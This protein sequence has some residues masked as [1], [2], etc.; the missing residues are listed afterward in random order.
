MKKTVAAVMV[1]AFVAAAAVAFAAKS[2]NC[3]VDAVEGDKVTMTCEKT[4]LKAGTEVK[5]QPKSEKKVEGC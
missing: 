1:A 2:E 4:E 5:V 3:K